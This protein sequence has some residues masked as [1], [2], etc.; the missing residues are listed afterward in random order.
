VA[1]LKMFHAHHLGTVISLLDTEANKNPDKPALVFK[2][3]QISYHEIYTQANQISHWLHT[4]GVKLGDRVMLLGKNSEKIVSGIFGCLKAGA[5]FVPVHPKIQSAKLEYIMH[6]CDPKA[7][8]VDPEMWET[9]Q[10]LQSNRGSTLITSLPN[11]VDRPGNITGW[12][13]LLLHSPHSLNKKVN[14]TDIAAI[15]YTSG[16]TKFP[17]GVVERHR[18]ILFATTAIN[19]VIGNT[20]ADIILCGIPL[21]FDYGLY[22]IFL[23]FQAGATIVLEEEFSIPMSIPQLLVQHNVTGFPGVPSLFALLLNTRLF[24]RVNLPSLRYITSTGDVFP[25]ANI[26]KLRSLLPN[27]EIFP[28]YGLTECKRVSIVPRGYLSNHEDSVGCPLPGTSVKIINELGAEVI[29]GEVGELIV[30][31]G[32]VMS[33]YWNDPEETDRRFKFLQTEHPALC[34]GDYFRQDKDGFLYFEG[35]KE[36]FIKSHGQKI[37]PTEIESFLYTIP[38]IGE[39]VVVGL[40]DSILGEVICVYAYSRRSSSE[41]KEIIKDKCKEYLPPIERPKYIL[42]KNEFL[43]KTQNGKLDRSS[44]KKLALEE[45]CNFNQ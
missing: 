44:I 15:I 23:A 10:M 9:H 35:R 17:K 43:P 27:V 24:E 40:P 25:K 45:C 22:Q 33:G 42:V 38:D 26:L 39:A 31:G 4:S 8:I 36:M 34:T 5:I 28:M 18:Q 37:S 19:S 7:I 29:M 14:S 2:N 3:R 16:S 1:G 11:N 21:S 41:M 13:D 20:A 30:H 32:H 6:D 12:D